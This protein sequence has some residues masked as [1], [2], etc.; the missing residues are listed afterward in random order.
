MPCLDGREQQW[1]EEDRAER[2][3]MKANY[4]FLEA[5]LCGALKALDIAHAG[6]RGD[7]LDII[8]YKEAGILKEDLI[9]WK[10][11]H[12]AEDARRKTEEK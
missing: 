4:A 7:G 8:D 11:E 6:Y 2:A 12:D 3:K 5:A 10:T 9:R 1:E